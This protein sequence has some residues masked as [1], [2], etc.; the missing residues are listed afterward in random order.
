MSSKQCGA[1]EDLDAAVH[2]GA[3]YCTFSSCKILA[4]AQ[5]EQV[6][7]VVPEYVLTSQAMYAV[8]ASAYL[9]AEHAT[10][11]IGFVDPDNEDVPAAQLMQMLAPVPAEYVPSPQSTQ[12]LAT[13]DPVVVRY[14]PVLYSV[15]R[16]AW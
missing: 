16:G 7:Y 12:E 3:C 8:T 6:M 13:V 5:L 4:A 15:H 1:L 10:Q 14:L 11:S 9:S 2:T